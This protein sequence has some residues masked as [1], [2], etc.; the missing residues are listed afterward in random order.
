MMQPWRTRVLCE[1]A[2]YRPRQF[3]YH[4][5]LEGLML[6]GTIRGE[7]VLADVLQGRATR[8]FAKGMS[9]DTHDPILG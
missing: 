5:S 9:A 1:G 6:F 2:G 7:V 8:T 3:E 4:P